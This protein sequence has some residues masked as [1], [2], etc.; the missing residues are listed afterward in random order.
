LFGLTRKFLLILALLFGSPVYAEEKL[1]VYPKTI[2]ETCFAGRAV[3]YDECGLQKDVLNN[4]L[5]EANKTGKTV[6]VV[7]GAE[8][9]IWCH[10]LKEHIKGNYGKFSYKLEG[11]SG[12][13]MDERPSEKDIK[14]AKKLA[15]FAAKTFVI[16]N[17]EAQHSFDGYDVL[18]E[19]GG[20]DHIK[21]Y[22][23]FVFTVDKSGK[24]QRA[25]PSTNEMK[26]LEKRR[27]GDDWYRGY[28]RG[29][30]QTELKKLLR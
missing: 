9:C 25:M 17:I 8:W 10:V 20:A 21:N 18:H 7:Y 27:E 29:V 24:F 2:N 5:R 19:T 28:N 3:T 14:Q 1:S 26:A 15:D 4:A 23:P 12:Y 11:Q 22:I 13:K 6:L 16:A 30:L